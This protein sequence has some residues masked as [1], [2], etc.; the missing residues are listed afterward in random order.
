MSFNNNEGLHRSSWFVENQSL[1]M[2]LP[3]IDLDNDHANDNHH[4]SSNQSHTSTM[5]D[6]TRYA[7]DLLSLSDN[8]YKVNATSSNSTNNITNLFNDNII[9]SS[10]NGSPYSTHSV[11]GTSIAPNILE[12]PLNT[13]A[14]SEL[15]SLI[16]SLR[17]ELSDL[18]Q[19]QGIQSNIPPVPMTPTTRQATNT[20]SPTVECQSI[21]VDPTPSP[22]SSQIS[23][24]THTTFAFASNRQ[25]KLHP[26][27]NQLQT[28]I[29]SQWSAPDP[30]EDNPRVSNYPKTSKPK[31]VQFEPRNE[32]IASN[33]HTNTSN[34]TGKPSTPT[35]Y[36]IASP[37][38][39]LAVLPVETTQLNLQ[40]AL[41]NIV[42]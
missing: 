41:Q 38:E 23:S 5:Y 35:A 11:S 21:H 40:Q 28:S 12:A 3:L 31:S 33:L 18:R 29:S 7:S 42:I 15:Q 16:H 36:V 24:T 2:D 1:P 17:E 25:S 27:D 13:S 26:D 37:V 9:Q 14:I 6:N 32:S 34:L 10:T 39:A 19:Q 20:P 22:T 30:P 8:D 4:Q